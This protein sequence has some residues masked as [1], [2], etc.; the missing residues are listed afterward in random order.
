MEV[1][2]RVVK[3]KMPSLNHTQILVTWKAGALKNSLSFN[4]MSQ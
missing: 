3:E 2:D 4:S 1:Q